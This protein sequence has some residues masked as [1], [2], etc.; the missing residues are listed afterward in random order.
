MATT[1]GSQGE[2]G[3]ES[4]NK[5]TENIKQA[6]CHH[7]YTLGDLKAK[8]NEYKEHLH[9]LGGLEGFA[10]SLVDRHGRVMDSLIV[11]LQNV[12]FKGCGM[13]CIEPHYQEQND[14]PLTYLA[15]TFGL[16]L[17]ATTVLALCRQGHPR[18]I[19]SKGGRATNQD[20]GNRRFSPGAKGNQERAARAQEPR[21]IKKTLL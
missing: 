3:T 16:S 11:D 10:G 12:G 4:D 19:G 2:A 8:L 5:N 21:A 14:H 18:R 1:S 17:S 6:A 9:T 20:E 15:A 7:P 13:R